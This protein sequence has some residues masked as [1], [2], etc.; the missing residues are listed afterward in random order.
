MLWDLG[1]YVMKTII[2]WVVQESWYLRDFCCSW[3]FA[4]CETSLFMRPWVVYGT[5]GCVW[6]VD[7]YNTMDCVGVLFF[8]M[9][10]CSWDFV[11]YE[12]LLSMRLLLWMRW[13]QKKKDTVDS[14]VNRRKKRRRKMPIIPGWCYLWE[15]ER[16]NTHISWC[17]LKE[18][19]NKT[20]TEMEQDKKK[21]KK[22]L[23][24][25]YVVIYWDR[26]GEHN[27]T[28]THRK[29]IW[30]GEKTN[31]FWAEW[32]VVLYFMRRKERKKNTHTYTQTH[33][34]THGHAHTHTCR[35][36][37]WRGETKQ[38]CTPPYTRREKIR[39][40]VGYRFW[41]N[42]GKSLGQPSIN[43]QCGSRRTYE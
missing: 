33:T 13:R 39:V 43:H 7:N 23:S 21:K 41:W 31:C 37:N 6:V 4:F 9:I 27:N 1:V 18:D 34:H 19:K 28:T 17:K 42:E 3:D 35:T 10:C 29:V 12:T 5:L 38:S 26:E 36:E 11:V 32:M 40:L 14:Y 22:A 20:E 25:Q 8:V 15:T 16:E 2:P 24:Y 30:M